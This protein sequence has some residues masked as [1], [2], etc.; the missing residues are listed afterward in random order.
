LIDFGKYLF[1]IIQKWKGNKVAGSQGGKVAGEQG[2]RVKGWERWNGE[3]IGK[4]RNG[5]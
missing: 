2:K 1:Q 5:S 3:E 4:W